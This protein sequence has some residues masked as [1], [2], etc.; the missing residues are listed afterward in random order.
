MTLPDGLLAAARNY[1]D[2]TWPDPD[3][4][5]KLSGIL[6]R[7]IKRLNGV[8]GTTL[9]FTVEDTP[10]ELLLDYARYVRAEALD[11]FQSNYLHELL[12][13][14]IREETARIEAER[15]QGADV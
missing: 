1:L 10:R 9:D 15:R 6:L 7:G 4:D 12:N 14:Q 11:E 13:L 5:E 8:A 3:G 2:I